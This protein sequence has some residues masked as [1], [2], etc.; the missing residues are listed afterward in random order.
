MTFDKLRQLLSKKLGQTYSADLL[1]LLASR[2]W[3]QY[4]QMPWHCQDEWAWAKHI[5]RM[6]SA[7][8]SQTVVRKGA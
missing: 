7:W 1:G 5:E 8:I 4:Q 6:D 2:L 3:V